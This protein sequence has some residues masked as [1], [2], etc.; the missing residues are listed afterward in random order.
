M[1]WRIVVSC[2]LTTAHHLRGRGACGEGTLLRRV[3]PA[4][5]KPTAAPRLV[6][7]LVRWPRWG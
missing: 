5:G 3:G 6:H 7:A 2:Q 1:G 4:L